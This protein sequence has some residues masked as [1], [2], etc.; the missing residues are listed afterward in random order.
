MTRGSAASSTSRTG[1]APEAPEARAEATPEARFAPVSLDRTSTP[2]AW[3]AATSRRV[4]VVLPLVPE[5]TTA[6]R[7]AASSPMTPGATARTTRPPIV[8]PAPIPARRETRPASRPARTA[9]AVRAERG[10]GELG[11]LI[12][13]LIWAQAYSA[14]SGPQK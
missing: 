11:G 12:D 14:M 13:G 7:P 1:L 8:T 6:P 2:E 9:R 4:V 10:D 3:R 5:T